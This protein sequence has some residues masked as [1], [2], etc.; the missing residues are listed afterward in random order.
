MNAITD[1]IIKQVNDNFDP[2]TH[3]APKYDL[4]GRLVKYNFDI[5][6]SFFFSKR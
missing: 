5:E 4:F 2:L 6:K 1:N 3:S